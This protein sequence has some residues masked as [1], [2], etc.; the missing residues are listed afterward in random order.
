MVNNHKNFEKNILG[1]LLLA[2][3]VMISG[4]ATTEYN[5]LPE[6]P[7]VIVPPKVEKPQGIYHK[8]QKG[9]TLWQISKTY[10]LSV[11]EIISANNIPNAAA[12][13]VNQL[14]LIPGAKQVKD[15]V[16]PPASSAATPDQNKDE[17]A[18]PLRGKII[19]YFKDPKGEGVNRGIDIDAAQGSS[20]KASREGRV[21]LADKM[22]EYNQTVMI[23]HEDGYV[24]I[25]T[26]NRKLLVSPGQRVYK[27]DVIAEVG[28]T[29][30]K[31]FLHFE[32]RKGK[33]ATNPLFYLP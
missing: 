5:R 9:Q 20:V 31:S 15:I 26:N 30:N 6:T 22:S 8:V 25:Y 19:S 18:W 24:S 27:G 28:A 16:M 11:E 32:I 29:A 12:I 14:L 2:S 33:E 7:K 17:F 3:I 10:G 21:V 23:D 4:C 1:A 13:E